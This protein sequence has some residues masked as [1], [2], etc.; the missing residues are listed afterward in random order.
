MLTDTQKSD[1]KVKLEAEKFLLQEELAGLGTQNPATPG[2]WEA[3]KPAGEVFGADQT[4]NADIIELEQQNNAA[5]NELEGRFNTVMHALNKFASG[6]YGVCE[7]SGHDI[8]IERL[9]AN[10]AARTCKAHMG[11]ERTLG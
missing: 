4:D 6:T 3:A 10:P 5:M 8:E 11:E 2:D 7:V 1:F 9:N